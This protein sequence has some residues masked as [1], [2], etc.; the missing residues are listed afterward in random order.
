MLGLVIKRE[1]TTLL[2]SKAMKISTTV[3]VLLFLVAGLVGRFLLNDDD[4]SVNVADSMTIG[5][6][7]EAVPLIPYL[8]AG[9]FME[10][11]EIGDADP[12]E[13][14][15]ADGVDF[16]AIISGE[17]ESPIISSSSQS[18]PVR[19]IAVLAATEYLVDQ[20]GA[21]TPGAF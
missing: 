8:D 13:A 3:L 19:E 18:T 21:L 20:N 2:G 6:T 11:E 16:E 1:F 12:R 4:E 10:I 14:Y 17:P 15:N 9:P 7:T 5:V